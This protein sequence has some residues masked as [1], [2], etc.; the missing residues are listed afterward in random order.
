MNP[1]TASVATVVAAVAVLGALGTSVV[2]C[3]RTR[4]RVPP[5]PGAFY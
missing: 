1:P 5:V 4:E 3:R 2:D